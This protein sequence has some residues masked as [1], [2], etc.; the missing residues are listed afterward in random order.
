MNKI[1]NI[2]LGGY[3]LT[4]D[5]DA[6]EYLSQYS[7]SIRRRFSESEGRDEIVSDIETRLGELISQSMGTR[8]IVM[9]PD[10][11]AA[12]SIMGKPEDFGEADESASTSSKSKSTATGGSSQQRSSGSQSIKT[13]KRL[14]RDEEDAVVSGVCSGL[15]AYFGMTDPVWMRLIFV[16]FAF[17]S[18]GFWVPAY[19]LLWILVPPARTAADRLAMRGEQ[20]NMDNIAREVEQG[21]DRL[22][23]SLNQ[24]KTTPG[25]NALNTTMTTVGQIFGMLLRFISKFALLIALLIAI[26]LFLAMAAG[27]ISSIWALMVAAPFLDFLSPYSGAT[28]WLAIGN[29][30]FVFG[31]PLVGLALLFAKVLFKV[32]T[33]GWLSSGMT[34]F[35]IV[36]LISGIFLVGFAIK[37]Y[38][39]TGSISTEVDLSTLR[40]DTLRIDGI[41]NMANSDDDR[42]GIFFDEGDVRVNE[43]GLF[44]KGPL[45]IRVFKSPTDRFRCTRIVKAQGNNSLNAQENAAVVDFPINFNGSTLFV[46][47]SYTISKGTKWRGQRIRVNIEVPVGKS[48]VFND[49]IYTYAAA[50]L[51][52]YD[53]DADGHYISKNPNQVFR[54]NNDGIICTSC[55]GFG[56][57]G[58]KGNRDYERFVIEGDFDVEIR[59]DDDFEVNITGNDRGAVQVIRSGD[60]ITFTSNGKS[61][62]KGAKVLIQASTFTSLIADNAGDITI[63]GFDEGSASISARGT[64]NIK[65]VMDVSERLNVMLSGN[66]ALD[67][68]GR[69]RDLEVSLSD[70]ANLDAQG[71][72]AENI[73]V[74]ASDASKGRV[75]ARQSAVVVSDGSSNVKVDG[76]A[77]VR[78]S[79]D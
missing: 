41:V 31:I 73:D 48:F 37:D 71:W 60:Q 16:L 79:R 28:N 58:Y 3:A 26:A 34:L 51:D 78:R 62:G 76:G 63:R 50:D 12:I 53:E 61:V 75:F 24:A 21:F 44:M 72:Q 33:P 8:T 77:E 4:I 2:N 67:L 49:K 13:G 59:Q 11:E 54:M 5:D 35:W 15:S 55:P 47:T 57:K 30:F 32:K 69:G 20:I 74:S 17:L 40:S 9:L 42:N 39:S 1:L 43:N 18:F 25:Q 36:N 23:Q 38:R 68:T 6:Y 10:V 22:G 45:E 65:A 52:Y 27:W 64:G 7:E 46:P 19:I 70:Q 66:C 29:A 56:E 14:F